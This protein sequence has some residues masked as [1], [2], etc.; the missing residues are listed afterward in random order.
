MV[1]ALKSIFLFNYPIWVC[2]LAP[3]VQMSEAEH[4]K[5]VS[6]T[7]P[8]GYMKSPDNKE[9]YQRYGVRADCT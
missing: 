4:G 6:A 7:V 8:F 2:I 3:F 1:Y 9:Q 5:R